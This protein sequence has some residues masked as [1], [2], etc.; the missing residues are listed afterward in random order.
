MC[1]RSAAFL[2]GVCM[3]LSVKFR[4]CAGN[5][6]SEANVSVLRL[7]GSVYKETCGDRSQH[8]T[9]KQTVSVGRCQAPPM[10]MGS[11]VKVEAATKAI[12]VNSGV[13]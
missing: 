7:P 9:E 11:F 13:G 3:F 8:Q 6:S 2:P 12:R 1:G 5:R 4:C 10:K